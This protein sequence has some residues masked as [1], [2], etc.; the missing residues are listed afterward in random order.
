M[1]LFKAR[2]SSNDFN[3]ISTSASSVVAID[4]D[5]PVTIISCNNTLQQCNE[6]IQHPDLSNGSLANSNKT[7]NG[8]AIDSSSTA[9]TAQHQFN[10]KSILASA[11]NP[12]GDI[13]Q[14]QQQQQQ[15][16]MHQS[17]YQHHLYPSHLTVGCDGTDVNN[18][19]VA[20]QRHT[21]RQH[22][23]NHNI[24]TTTNQQRHRDLVIHNHSVSGSTSSNN[25]NNDIHFNN[26][27][28]NINGNDL[29]YQNG[30]ATIQHQQCGDQL[31]QMNSDVIRRRS[32]ITTTTNT[33]STAVTNDN[34]VMLSD[35][36]DMKNDCN[37]K[38]KNKNNFEIMWNH[39]KHNDKKLNG[40][41]VDLIIGNCNSRKMKR[42]ESLD[43][44]SITSGMGRNGKC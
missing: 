39:N 18:Q 6:T 30:I 38:I 36:T 20:V 11:K 34:Q 19:T 42:S 3:T 8:T 17:H 32:I 25:N 2:K 23:L 14:Q 41:A 1:R 12:S 31:N 24:Q 21:N 37:N 10:T 16:L 15:Q 35:K 9:A 43:G 44:T 13:K 22:H 7:S 28:I 29:N 40:D 27:N 33:S 4:S 5:S 26:N